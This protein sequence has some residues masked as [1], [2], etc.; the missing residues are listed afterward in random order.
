MEAIISSL[1]NLL[2]EL[3]V[4]ST[5]NETWVID[6]K[7][8]YGFSKTIDQVD[9]KQAS[10]S[11]VQGGS[12]IAAHTEHLRWSIRVALEFFNGKMPSPDWAESWKVKQVNEEEWKKLQQDLLKAYQDLKNGIAERKDWS[13]EQFNQGVLALVPHAAYHLGAIRQLI[14]ATR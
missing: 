2:E 5:G 4:G 14:I 1:L 7:P 13:S 9:A 10:T 6:Q 12:T 8:G 11:T 3:Y